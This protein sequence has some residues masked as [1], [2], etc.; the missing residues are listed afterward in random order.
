MVVDF[1]AEMAKKD[2]EMAK[3]DAEIAKL[4]ARQQRE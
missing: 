4:Q 2:A 3:K 1:A